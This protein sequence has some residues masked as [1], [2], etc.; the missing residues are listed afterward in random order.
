MDDRWEELKALEEQE[1]N[2]LT[3]YG[4]D[5][6]EQLKKEMNSYKSGI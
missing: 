6:L 1:E 3:A 5:T 4:K 2:N